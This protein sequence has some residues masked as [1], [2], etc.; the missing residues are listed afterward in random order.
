MKVRVHTKQFGVREG[1]GDIEGVKR[2][3]E[4]GRE[5]KKQR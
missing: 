4:G 5:T 3:R 1:D 2:E